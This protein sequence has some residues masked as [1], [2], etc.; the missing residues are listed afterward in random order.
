MLVVKM[1]I[2]SSEKYAG[3]KSLK[4]LASKDNNAVKFAVNPDNAM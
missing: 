2:E 4:T 1:L 3:L